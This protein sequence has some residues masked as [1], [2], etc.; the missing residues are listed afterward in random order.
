MGLCFASEARCH[1]LSER[2]LLR[3][4]FMWVFLTSHMVCLDA[5][6]D[7]PAAAVY[8]NVLLNSIAS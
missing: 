6:A 8:A 7:N 1:V 3:Q 4:S 5:Q 2:A